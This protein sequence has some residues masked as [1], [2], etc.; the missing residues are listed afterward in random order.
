MAALVPFVKP[1]AITTLAPATSE[2]SAELVAVQV[3]NIIR[4]SLGWD[5]DQVADATYTQVVSPSNMLEA[6]VLP[7]L[8]L[9]AVASVVVDGSALASSAYNATSSGVVYLDG[10]YAYKS[11]TVT[12]T[13]GWVREPDTLP[14]TLSAVALDYALRMI[15]N[16]TGVKAYSMGNASET[17][18]VDLAEIAATDNR[19]DPWR[20]NQ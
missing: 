3:S 10:C 18:A 1:G 17:F 20:V 4:G 9:T 2:A 11:V 8:N 13:A 5:V 15:G 7:A 19:L 16:P 12:Y 14:G 6:V